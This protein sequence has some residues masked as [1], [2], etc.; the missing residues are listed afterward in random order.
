MEF[1]DGEILEGKVANNADLLTS[2][3]LV[4]FPS[5]QETN[6]QCVFVLKSAVKKFAILSV[7]Q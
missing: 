5:D 2:A 4:L 6:N 3:G 7:A 1:L